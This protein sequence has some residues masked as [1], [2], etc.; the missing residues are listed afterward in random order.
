MNIIFKPLDLSHADEFRA[1][2]LRAIQN[3]PTALLETLEEEQVK[4][5][6]WYNYVI[7][8]DVVIGC[9]VDDC[10]SGLSIMSYSIAKKQRHRALQWG[11]YIDPSYRGMSLGKQVL[12]AVGDEAPKH[13]I[14]QLL[15]GVMGSNTV[16]LHTHKV[17]GYMEFFREKG[18]IMENGVLYDL[19]HV[20]KYL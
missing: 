7:Q 13:G 6:K 8:H 11:T 2:R 10:L 4:T 20:I 1:I 15:G 3:D 9:F 16:A 14:T 18:G 19:V 12:L 17:C 5:I